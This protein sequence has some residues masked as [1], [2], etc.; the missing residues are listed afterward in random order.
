MGRAV[1]HSIPVGIAPAWCHEHLP[2][3]QSN[4]QLIEYAKHVGAWINGFFLR[5]R[6]HVPSPNVIDHFERHSIIEL[7]LMVVL[8][9]VED[10]G[11]CSRQAAT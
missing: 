11:R 9:K 4:A 8:S 7:T 6:Y 3:I 5:G 10:V 1:S 2:A